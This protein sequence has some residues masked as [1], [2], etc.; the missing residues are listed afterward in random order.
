MNKP[1][2]IGITGGSGSGKT[3]F[4]QRLS[5]FFKPEEICLISQDNYYNPHDQQAVDE[6]GRQALKEMGFSRAAPA[7]NANCKRLI[8][9]PRDSPRPIV[10]KNSTNFFIAMAR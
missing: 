10:F 1:F 6:Q 4:L 9:S 8:H 7:G 3:Y 5:S 2:T